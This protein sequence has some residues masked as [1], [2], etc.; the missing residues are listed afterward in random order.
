MGDVKVSN[1][2]PVQAASE[3][4]KPQK[5]ESALSKHLSGIKNAL[6]G[7]TGM[8]ALAGAASGALLA[9]PAGALVGGVAGLAI[10]TGTQAFEK[11]N[12]TAGVI[13]TAASGA[14]LGVAF[15]LP[16]LLVGG[17]AYLFA[18][19]TAQKGAEK[20]ANFLKGNQPETAPAQ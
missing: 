16:G 15:G 17:S 9:G 3:V 8:S 7:K 14:L 6:F 12:K 11:G 1:S 20:I 18:S 19:G 5:A 13:N 2:A 10:G 4:S